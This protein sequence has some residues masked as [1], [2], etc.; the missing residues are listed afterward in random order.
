MYTLPFPSRKLVCFWVSDTPEGGTVKT[1]FFHDVSETG[2]MVQVEAGT[3][4][5]ERIRVC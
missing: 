3:S 5:S 4:I 2:S 1:N